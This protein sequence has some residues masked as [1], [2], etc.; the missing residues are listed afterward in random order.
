M[1]HFLDFHEYE[2]YWAN[3]CIEWSIDGQLMRR[4]TDYV[5]LHDMQL[6]FNTW[7]PLYGGFE[8]ALDP[9]LQTADNAGDNI[10][11]I[12][13][14]D[15]ARA[16]SFDRIDLDR[17]EIV[18]TADLALLIEHFGMSD[19]ASTADGDLSFDSAVD[20]RD[21][22][23]FLS[24]YNESATLTADTTTVPEPTGLLLLLVGLM[25]MAGLRASFVAE[26]L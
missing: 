20:G 7:A 17:N 25:S 18:D 8:R 4:L 15:F 6:Y 24:A 5:P 26:S 16:E 14:L 9:T 11:V 12:W 19:S 1:I 21:L 10:D 13:Q 22:N 3:S 23:L 2:I